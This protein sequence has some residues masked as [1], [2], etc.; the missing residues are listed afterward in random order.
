MKKE[1]KKDL[2]ILIV[3]VLSFVIPLATSALLDIN[4]I[5]A[6]WIRVILVVILI[7]FQITIGVF[8][9]KEHI[10]K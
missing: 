3:I 8:V 10:K 1:T 5:T 2:K 9:L 6:H 4:W 7:A